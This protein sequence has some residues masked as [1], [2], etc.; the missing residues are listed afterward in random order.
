[1]FY[2]GELKGPGKKEIHKIAPDFGA[3]TRH[4]H[5]RVSRYVAVDVTR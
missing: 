4:I 1:M 5:Q 2:S 3:S